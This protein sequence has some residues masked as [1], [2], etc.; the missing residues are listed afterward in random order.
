MHG[1]A[2][3]AASTSG[4]LSFNREYLEMKPTE[5]ESIL[6][7]SGMTQ[8]GRPE[9]SWSG[10]GTPPRQIVS[11]EYSFNFP[12]RAN[13][14]ARSRN[15]CARSIRSRD[16]LDGSFLDAESPALH[17]ICMLKVIIPTLNAAQS[18]PQ[19]ASALLRCVRPE[20]VLIVDSESTD[21][22]VALASEAGFTV[23]SV[24]RSGF[25]HGGTRQRAAEMVT[26][27]DILIYMTQDA[28]LADTEA[29]KNLLAVFDDSQVAAA[30][31]RQL[32][33]PMAGAI[34]AHARHFNYSATPEVRSL[35]SR[36][37]LGIKTIFLSDS[38][39]A[40]RRSALMEVGGFPEDTIFGEDTITA[41]RLLLAGYKVAYAAEARAY[42]SHSYTCMQEFRR[43]FDIGVL[44]NRERWILDEFGQAHGEG[45]RFVLSELRY[46]WKRDALRIPSA[47]M[48]TGAK[49]IGYRMGR[50]EA[51]F[52]PE[53]KR[54][55]S[56]NPKF[57]VPVAASEEAKQGQH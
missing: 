53:V 34:E 55:L 57:W 16:P 27:A 43:Y 8:P 45:K 51:H 50:M 3:V 12:R 25:S 9:Y 35:E 33:R 20:Q 13:S 17:L 18:W 47:L 21:D 19:F 36:R 41:A 42:H 23:H 31:G 5:T 44:H 54:K 11:Q 39:S 32:P 2:F 38:L 28:I 14:L 52:S 26:D 22:T 7:T 6:F 37:R 40:Y 29:I 30:Y 4:Y 1:C 46:L 48:R 15:T 10:S 24:S 49:L 56:M